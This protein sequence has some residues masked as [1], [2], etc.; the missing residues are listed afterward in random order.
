[1]IVTS[2]D[3]NGENPLFPSSQYFDQ[4]MMLNMWSEGVWLVDKQ[5]SQFQ[6]IVATA[7]AIAKSFGDKEAIEKL[8]PLL[9]LKTQDENFISK[10]T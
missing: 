6:E 10:T 4:F 1:M 3:L 8:E 9:K 7:L 2:R 5:H